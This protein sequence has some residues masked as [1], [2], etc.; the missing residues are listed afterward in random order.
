MKHIQDCLKFSTS[1]HLS[2]KLQLLL[3]SVSRN[4]LFHAAL[5]VSFVSFL[6]RCEQ[7]GSK[8]VRVLSTR[9]VPVR[10]CSALP[11]LF[12]GGR[13]SFLS[14]WFLWPVEHSELPLW[15]ASHNN[16]FSRG[17]AWVKSTSRLDRGIIQIFAHH[18]YDVMYVYAEIHVLPGFCSNLV[19]TGRI[20]AIS[21][22][23]NSNQ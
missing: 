18:S 13:L 7:H 17:M 1:G 20:A 15:F 10:D 3:P 19:S 4:A 12:W 16:P 8:R 22:C 6:L 9:L 23:V 5:V 2:E 14:V 11:S 21:L